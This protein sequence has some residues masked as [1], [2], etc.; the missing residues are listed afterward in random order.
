M[1]LNTG[2]TH[3]SFP[4]RLDVHK[5]DLTELQA[6]EIIKSLPNSGM[7]VLI[8][9]LKNATEII[10]LVRF[11][12]C[13]VIQ[14]HGSIDINEI[15]TIKIEIP[16]IIIWKSLIVKQDNIGELTI[17]LSKFEPYIDA[18]ITDTYDPVSGA[19]G[20]TGMAHD[21]EISK[22]LVSISKKPVILA[23]G[24]NAE[25]VFDAIVNVQPAGV[26]AHT[27]LENPDGRKDIGKCREFVAE[28][29]RGFRVIHR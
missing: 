11:L 25:N 15:K 24:L 1:V 20:A 8:T 19:S 3:L 12:G 28:A 10:D 26:D 18:F 22:K 27:G 2:A 5:E 6:A 21:W 7:A 29:K 17:T 4:L 14:L 16:E 23:G 9:Y 13:T